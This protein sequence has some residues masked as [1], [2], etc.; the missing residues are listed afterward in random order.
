MQDTQ[1]RYGRALCG[2]QVLTRLSPP[3]PRPR[4]SMSPLG[5]RTNSFPAS[6]TLTSTFLEAWN[7]LRLAIVLDRPSLLTLFLLS[8][9]LDLE[10]PRLL[11]VQSER[12]AERR[13]SHSRRP[14]R[15]R[16]ENGIII[17]F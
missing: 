11:L 14:P 1:K 17:K 12:F 4:I 13:D 8:S 7:I 9:L 5:H 10:L 2:F 15:R 3:Q 6:I 16:P